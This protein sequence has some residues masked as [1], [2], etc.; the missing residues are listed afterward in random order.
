MTLTDKQYQGLQIAVQRYRSKEPYTVVS[1]YAGTGKAQPIDTLIPT[2]T[3]WR[4]LG[5]LKIGD[6]VYD[7]T[8]QP[9]KVLGVFPQGK[10]QVYTICLKDGRKSKCAGDHLWTVL[11]K[12]NQEQTLTT[13]EL[14][15]KGLTNSAGF[16][17]AVPNNSPVEYP[18]INYSI[19]PYVVGAF[20]GDGCCKQRQLTL[21]SENE[22]IPNIV[23]KL[24]G[25]KEVCR[26]SSQNYNWTFT[27]EE[28]VTNIDNPAYSILKFQTNTFFIDFQKELCC[29]AQEKSIPD[30]Y[31]RGSIQQ[32]LDLLQ[33]L[34]DTDGSIIDSEKRFNV[35][36][37]STSYHLIL[38]VQEVLWSLG[39]SSTITKDKRSEK[40]TTDIC[41]NLNVNIPNEEKF[42][43]FRLQRKKEIAY[44][45]Q[46]YIKHKNY[47]KN[48]I[49]DIFKEPYE[50]EMVCIYVDNSEHLYLT[51]DYIVTHNTTLV[52][53]IIDALNLDKEND[54]AFIAYTGKAAKVL[55]SKG[56]KN[57]MTAHKLLYKAVKNPN[58]TYR[59]Y[60]KLTI[61]DYKLIVVDEVSMLPKKMWELLLSHHIPVLA[62]GDPGQ[63]PALT[64]GTDI[65]NNPHVFLDEIM[66]QAQESEIIRLSMD[67]RNGKLIKPFKGK[68]VNVVCASDLNQGMLA[69][70]DQIICAKNDT[71]YYLNDVC[72]KLFWGVDSGAL[73]VVGDKIICLHND[74]KKL[75]SLEDPLINGAIGTIKNYKVLYDKDLKDNILKLDF[76]PEEYDD[77]NLLG[78]FSMDNVD[79]NQLVNHT[80][81]V[82]QDNYY[83]LPKSYKLQ[84]FDYGY[85]ITC[86]KAQGSEYQKVLGIEENF[87][88]KQEEHK[89]YLY[90]LVTRASEKLTL[91]LKN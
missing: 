51:N 74:W 83:L 70:A 62:T 90:T 66:R 59:F 26:N 80:P 31:K 76:M 75:N 30:I 58:G 11:N 17:Y 53:F 43:L 15:K 28:P 19:D 7:R 24:I 81:S 40:Y 27:F 21:S 72:R 23:K 54:V 46:N 4:K 49:I 9:T 52:N 39:Y 63:L 35:R 29:A 57:A 5:E 55:K 89:R 2:P 25:A 6:Y 77:N 1:G 65:L 73:P 20:L 36:F 85:A 3:G 69:W 60:P 8:G 61:D 32:R 22:E 44:K 41:Y 87:P 64:E 13:E 38:D 34:F 82:T 71:R 91:V 42:K 33:G 56:N 18:Q 50:T 88:F 14:L 67:I 84:S 47:T 79:Y 86:W 12:K 45:A 78:L 16:K 48:S 10:K 37:T 68:E